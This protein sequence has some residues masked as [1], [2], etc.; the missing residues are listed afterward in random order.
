MPL[1]NKNYLEL[2]IF[3]K[4]QEKGEALKA[5]RKSFL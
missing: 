1:W 4:Q 2:I 5:G 3:K